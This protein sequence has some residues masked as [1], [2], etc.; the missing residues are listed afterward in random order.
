[1]FRAVFK[2]LP[3]S[4]R[5]CSFR[6]GSEERALSWHDVLDLWT[7][8]SST[9]DGKDFQSCFRTSLARSFEDFYWECSP[10]CAETC[11][12]QSFEFVLID[13][14]RRLCSEAADDYDFRK[15]FQGVC[16][17]SP[18]HPRS[19]SVLSFRNLSGDARLVVPRHATTENDQIMCVKLLLRFHV[20]VRCSERA[21]IFQLC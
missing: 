1:M 18:N 20:Y 7:A 19:S 17:C 11:P 13:A 3:N 12:H 6:R 15:H 16:E 5:V 10:V 9:T 21:H 2:D 8:Q 4:R 14:N